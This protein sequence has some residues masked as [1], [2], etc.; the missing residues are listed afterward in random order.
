MLGIRTKHALLMRGLSRTDLRKAA[1]NL[2]KRK[3]RKFEQ[4]ETKLTKVRHLASG[5]LF[6][7]IRSLPSLALTHRDFKTPISNKDRNFASTRVA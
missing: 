5:K 7:R 2:N 1:K 6:V 4:K 3:Q